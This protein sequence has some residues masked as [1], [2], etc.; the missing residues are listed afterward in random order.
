MLVV[1]IGLMVV[2]RSVADDYVEVGKEMAACDKGN[3]IRFHG[4]D[5]AIKLKPDSATKVVDLL[6]ETSE[7]YFYCGGTR[8]REACKQ[9]FD[10]VQAERAGNGAIVFTFYRNT[11]A[12]PPY[13]RVGTTK[14]ACD[15]NNV[16]RITGKDGDI[17]IPADSSELVA[18]PASKKELFWYCGGTRERVANDESFDHVLVERAGNGAINWTFLKKK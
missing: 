9:A 5:G 6:A 1:V 10:A 15:K 17:K 11:K 18:L 4:K 13:D 2:G 16:V 14:D 12:K 3:E 7:L 8:E